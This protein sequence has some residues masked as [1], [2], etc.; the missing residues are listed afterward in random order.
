MNFDVILWSLFD[1]TF[2]SKNS[3]FIR[4]NSSDGFRRFV[5]GTRMELGDRLVNDKALKIVLVEDDELLA[6]AIKTEL[7]SNG[8]L[9]QHASNGLEAL[10]LIEQTEPD[11]LLLDVSV[12]QLNAF[13]IVERLR[14]TRFSNL[15]LVVHTS[16]DLTNDE[17]AQLTLGKT[18][19]ISKIK[20]CSS[21]LVE[22]VQRVAE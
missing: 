14:K 4:G 20:A 3:A 7:V 17:K 11:I 6:I 1:S 18:E 19:V 9:V 2:A 15:P 22:I 5:L 21:E 13:G 16:W 8:F 12:P 10:D